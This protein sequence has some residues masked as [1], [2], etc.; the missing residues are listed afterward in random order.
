TLRDSKGCTAFV[1]VT[2]TQPGLLTITID[3][4]ANVLCFGEAQGGI[5]ISV[6]GGTTPYSFNWSNSNTDQNDT[7]L[8]AGT[9]NVTV[10]DGHGCN[11][12]SGATITQPTLLSLNIATY[13]NLNCYN[14]SS[15]YVYVTAN[16]GV[17]PYAYA[18]SNGATT[19]DIT[20]LGPGTY[21]LTVT[22]ANGCQANIS[23]TI[24]QPTQLTSTISSTP[25]TCNGAANGTVT[26]TV[27][28]GT[29]PQTFLW[30]N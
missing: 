16:G 15:G 7:N 4:I 21:T 3:S 9:Y 19:Q 2:I 20:V 22:D 5:F 24:T 14:D 10:V 1:P 30:N 11:A 12:S 27:S 28:G 13:H 6:S 8:V 26:L 29:A 23:Q 18:W 25:V 17:P